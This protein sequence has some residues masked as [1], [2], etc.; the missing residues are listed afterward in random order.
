MNLKETFN[1]LC[2]KFKEF[3]LRYWLRKFYKK[4]K[5]KKIFVTGR[6]A[7]GKS[8]LTDFIKDGYYKNI[9][10]ESTLTAETYDIKWNELSDN[11]KKITDDAIH[12]VQINNKVVEY[13]KQNDIVFWLFN[14]KKIFN[15]EDSA[16]INKIKSE[17]KF[18]NDHVKNKTFIAIGTHIDYI[19]G[20]DKNENKIIKELKSNIHIQEIQDRCPNLSNIEY[21]SLHNKYIEKYVKQL[22]KTLLKGEKS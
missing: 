8:T 11:F 15:N 7:T 1:K 21:M 18:F 16:E 17:M 10:R 13:I 5:G 20:F 14:A 12:D 3:D 22:I 6:P 4:L 2:D 9:D 19:K